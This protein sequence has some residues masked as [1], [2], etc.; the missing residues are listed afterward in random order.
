MAYAAL[1]NGGQVYQPQLVRRVEAPDGTTIE[2]FQ[3]KVTRQTEIHPEHR[4]ILIEGLSAVVNDPGGTAYRSRLKDLHYAGKTGTA[5][6]GRLGAVRL[7][8]EQMEY[9]TRDHAW[10]ASFA[11]TEE[12]EIV[13]VVLNEHGVHGG[14]DAAPTAAAVI[15]KYFELKN[16]PPDAAMKV[17]FAPHDHSALG[18]DPMVPAP[19][20]A[21]VVRK[22]TAAQRAANE[23]TPPPPSVMP[24]LV[25]EKP[26]PNKDDERELLPLPPPPESMTSEKLVLPPAPVPNAPPAPLLPNPGAPASPPPDEPPKNLAREAEGEGETSVP[27]KLEAATQSHATAN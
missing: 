20:P 8:K 6:V 7:K 4:R 17:V 18:D 24:R 26:K 15:Q 9:F 23:P 5:Q 14:S 12:P 16:E 11:P 3:P 1:A 2:E 19:P 22:A 27:P 25:E 13:V 21:E 10:F